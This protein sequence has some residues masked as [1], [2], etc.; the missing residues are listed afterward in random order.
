MWNSEIIFSF[1]VATVAVACIDAYV[2]TNL[3]TVVST[4]YEETRSYS[5]NPQCKPSSLNKGIRCC[6][7]GPS[8]EIQGELVSE[9]RFFC[10]RISP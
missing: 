5:Q 6:D 7:V 9:L 2:T 3:N 8:I 4:H 1:F 10:I